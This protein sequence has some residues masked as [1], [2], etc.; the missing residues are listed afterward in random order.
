MFTPAPPSWFT[1]F[2]TSPDCLMSLMVRSDFIAVHRTTSAD[3]SLSQLCGL[4]IFVRIAQVVTQK[5][6]TDAK[7]WKSE[8][9][10]IQIHV[11]RTMIYILYFFNIKRKRKKKRLT[12]W[13]AQFSGQKGKQTFIFFRPYHTTCPIN[14]ANANQHFCKLCQERNSQYYRLLIPI[15]LEFAFYIPMWILTYVIHP[16]IWMKFET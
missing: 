12:Y 10:V 3:A 5:T 2:M 8:H 9:T 4:Q 16:L 14:L 15:K 1:L 11:Q 6:L 7:Q 13:P